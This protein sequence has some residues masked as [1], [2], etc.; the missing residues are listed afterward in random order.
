MKKLLIIALLFVG[1]EETDLLTE[2]THDDT[3]TIITDTLYVYGDT[4]YVID[5]LIFT[6][7]HGCL[8][9]EAINYDSTATIN[10]NSCEYET[11]Y[12]AVKYIFYDTWSV[13][14]GEIN[15][16][17]YTVHLCQADISEEL[18]LHK[19]S[20]GCKEYGFMTFTESCTS[21]LKHMGEWHMDCD[22]FCENWTNEEN[23][24]ECYQNINY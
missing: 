20:Q 21:G 1:C 9:S 24:W 10:N 2:H 15:P 14:Q 5:T 23:N 6:N 3:S 16:V 22:A 17:E 13:S 18:C 19:A 8:D 7:K 11:S 4:L 12:C